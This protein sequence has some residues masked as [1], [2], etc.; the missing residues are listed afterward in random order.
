VYWRL[1]V[2]TGYRIFHAQT[3]TLRK[4]I[5]IARRFFDFYFRHVS[6][7]KICP[8]PRRFRIRNSVGRLLFSATGGAFVLFLFGARVYRRFL[9]WNISY[10]PYTA[11]LFV[12]NRMRRCVRVYGWEREREREL[13]VALFE[14]HKIICILLSQY[15]T[16]VIFRTAAELRLFVT[17]RGNL[18]NVY[19]CIY[20]NVPDWSLDVTVVS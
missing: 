16:Q 2:F 6:F 9:P 7:A 3:F 8:P 19:W 18:K 4:W 15:I 10:R 11:P 17:R 12:S 5:R 14:K 13:V 20:N 1:C